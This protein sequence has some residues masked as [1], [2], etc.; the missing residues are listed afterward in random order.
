MSASRG[1][2]RW[3]LFLALFLV[4]VF[5]YGSFGSPYFL[6]ASNV[7]I[8]LAGAMPVAIVALAMTLVIVTGEIDISAGSMVGLCAV[9]IAVALESG[10]PIEA[11]MAMAVLTGALAGLFNGLII[12]FGGLPSLVVTIGTLALYRGLAQILLEERS[13][14]SFPVWYQDLGFGTVGATPLPWTTVLFGVLAAGFAVFLHATR[15]GRALFAIGNNREAVRYSGIDVRRAIVGV[16]VT[17]GVMCSIAAMVLTAYLA[18]ARSDTAIGM[19]LPVITAV[20][21]G[22]VSIFGGSGTMLG[23]LLALAVL[24]FVQNS[25]GLAG[26]MPEAQQIVIGA[27]LILT[28]VVFEG[29]ALV[30][31]W[32][33]ARRPARAVAPDRAPL[34][35][36]DSI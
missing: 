13:V 1:I 21:L 23:V 12:A 5:V 26:V 25:L 36:E 4:A 10:L 8:A 11:G 9:A 17:S 18:S 7:S 22:G 34:T 3:E 15:W 19:E 32:L 2:V 24:A 20:V 27:V 16:F 28:L 14:S 6:T 33:E 35:I 29:H 31:R 30:R